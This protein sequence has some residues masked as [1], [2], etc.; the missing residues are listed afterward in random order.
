MRPIRSILSFLLAFTNPLHVLASPNCPLEGPEFPPPQKLASHPIWQAAL[1]NF[2]SVFDFIDASNITGIDRFS[3]SIQIFST[4]PGDPILWE[5]HRTAKDLPADTAGVTSVDGN[6]VYRIGSV[7]KIFAVL[8]FLAEV[9]DVYWNQPITRVIPELAVLAGRAN[10]SNFDAVRETAW[11]DIT[12]GSLAAQISGL[13]RD[14]KI[15]FYLS[16]RTKLIKEQQQFFRGL[17]SAFLAYTPFQTATYSNNGYQILAYALESRS[18]KSFAN[19]LQDCIVKPLNLRRTFYE[20]APAALGVIPGIFKDTFWFANL[21]DASPG[22]NMYSSP[23]DLSTHGRAI[24]NSTLLKPAQTRRWL[25]PVTFTSD[26]AVSIGAPWG[27]RRIQLDAALQPYRTI[28]ALTKAGTFKS[29][30][31]FLSMIKEL[32]IGFTI[33]MAG[34]PGISNFAGAD[35]LGASLIPAYDAVARDEADKMYS[36]T[37]VNSAGSWLTISTNPRKPGL[38]VRPWISNGTDMVSLGM[39]LSSG[40]FLR[41][42]AL[43]PEV[44]LY[45]TGLKSRSGTDGGRREAWKSVVFDWV[46]PLDEFVFQVDGSGRVV[47]VMNLALRETLNKL[48]S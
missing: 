21:G 26:P 8:A 45:Y 3:Y 1:T 17:M 33:M 32:N 39:A 5:R 31:A 29:Y 9:G 16:I 36:G 30:T 23:N 37:Y 25:Q 38:G 22:G 40:D 14:C 47:S 19:I 6:P 46:L 18:K 15:T 13:Q 4:N 44:R 34:K 11:N 35:L 43:H 24:L 27:I 10:A 28:T 41:M 48:Q 12:I 20:I 42:P 7:S 2:S